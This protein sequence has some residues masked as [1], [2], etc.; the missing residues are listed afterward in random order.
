M[1]TSKG[2]FVAIER[3]NKLSEFKKLDLIDK[4]KIHGIESDKYFIYSRK[5]NNFMNKLSTV[6]KQMDIDIIAQH[7]VHN[8]HVDGFIERFNIAIEYDEHN[9][10]SN[11]ERDKEELRQK[12]IENELKCEFIRLS[13]TKTDEE[14]IGIV[15]N[16]LFKKLFKIA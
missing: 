16:S 13:D 9:N 3:N 10:H 6:L 8:Y 14:N 11:Y 7:K 5:E 1:T 12:V 15:I 2:F 4:L